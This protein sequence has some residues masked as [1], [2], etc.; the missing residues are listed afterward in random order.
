MIAKDPVDHFDIM[1]VQ[2]GYRPRYALWSGAL[3]M[4]S[5]GADD[6]DFSF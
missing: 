6:A 2:Y 4:L 5:A 3:R 1:V